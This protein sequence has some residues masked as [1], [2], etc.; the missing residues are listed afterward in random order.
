MRTICLFV[1]VFCVYFIGNSQEY[2]FRK[3][4]YRLEFKSYFSS[5]IILKEGLLCEVLDSS[6]PYRY[7][8]INL[9]EIDINK[10]NQLQ[11]EIKEIKL[12][13]YDSIIEDPNV[14]NYDLELI[15]YVFNPDLQVKKIHWLSGKDK[16]LSKI[17]KL[18]KECIPAEK[19]EK[20]WF[21]I[22]ME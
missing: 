2:E 22:P 5:I 20:Y 13:E 15:L 1:F 16:G 10:Y 19:R 8:F 14:K 9:D 6:V 11:K 17:I 4:F 7:E 3:E 21:P 12:F 18:V